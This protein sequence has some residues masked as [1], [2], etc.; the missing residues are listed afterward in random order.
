MKGEMSFKSFI[1]IRDNMRC[2]AHDRDYLICCSCV[3]L[4]LLRLSFT[5][6]FFIFGFICLDRQV[7]VEYCGNVTLS[8]NT[9]NSLDTAG[10]FI[11]A[12]SSLMLTSLIFSW[13]KFSPRNFFYAVPCLPQFWFWLILLV[14]AVISIVTIDFKN[15]MPLLGSSL[16]FEI[17]SL[18]VFCCA[19]R[20]I[21]K[22]T[23]KQWLEQKFINKFILARFMYFLFIATMWCYL[24]RNLVLFLYDTSIMAKKISRHDHFYNLDSLLL[25]TNCTTRGSF[26]Q[27]FYAKIFRRPRLPVVCENVFH[28]RTYDQ[29]GSMGVIDRSGGFQP[30]MRWETEIEEACNN[31]LVLQK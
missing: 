23:I 8:Q 27:F 28:A 2:F 24:I 16:I 15:D 26:T 30:I 18:L 11:E 3:V 10:T 22:L 12:G 9:K 19:L 6:L 29:Y 13:G 5:C 20:F 14:M 31:V 21:K 1:E 4:I 17:G 7:T 25:L